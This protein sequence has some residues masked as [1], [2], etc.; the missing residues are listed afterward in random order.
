MRVTMY[1][2]WRPT[3]SRYIRC[4]FHHFFHLVYP[5]LF[6]FGLRLLKKFLGQKNFLTVLI[7]PSVEPHPKVNN[8]KHIKQIETFFLQIK[9]SMFS[10]G[11]F[12]QL[13][14]SV[15]GWK[16]RGESRIHYNPWMQVSF[17]VCCLCI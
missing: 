8:N 4:C 7:P 5:L 16:V 6:S 14:F 1:V 11:F 17:L 10:F 3:Q 15:K 9:S 13:D 12:L 2:K